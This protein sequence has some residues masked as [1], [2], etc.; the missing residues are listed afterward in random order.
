MARKKFSRTERVRIFDLHAGRCHLCQ[1]KIQIGETW[2]L[3]HVVAWELTRD[4][5]DDNVKP[6]HASCH[7]TKTADD[8]RSIRKADRIR[9]KH[10]GAWPESKAK[11]RSRGF[12][13]SRHQ[14]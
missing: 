11:I 8:T 1:Q 10:I 7:K 14:P 13:N 2:E 12:A 3:E 4:D 6:A 5:S 9:A